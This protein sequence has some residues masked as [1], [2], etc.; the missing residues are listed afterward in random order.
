MNRIQAESGLNFGKGAEMT[1]P[2]Q[3]ASRVLRGGETCFSSGAPEDAGL[4]NALLRGL[5]RSRLTEDSFRA[6][7]GI[8]AAVMVTARDGTIEYVNEWFSALTGFTEEEVRGRTPRM[9]GA[10][11]IPAEYFRQL[12][13]T[14]QQGREWH[15]EFRNRRKSGETYWEFCSI[16]PL[17]NETGGIEHFL[18]LKTDVTRRTGSAV[19]QQR[20]VAELHR[21]LLAIN[22]FGQ[23]VRMCAWC[24]QVHDRDLGWTEGHSYLS[25]HSPVPIT[26][27]ICPDCMTVQLER[28]SRSRMQPAKFTFSRS[29]LASAR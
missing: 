19:E 14:L 7:M 13:T 8:P 4:Y 6:L 17:T 11:G 28:I 9:L 29:S 10:G 26:H 18:A 5:T 1:R 23:L 24:N 22:S 25:L 27:G 21:A 12:W 16:W 15:G 2:K 20:T 3:S